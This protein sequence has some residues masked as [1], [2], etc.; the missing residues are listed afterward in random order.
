MLQIMLSR[1]GVTLCCAGSLTCASAIGAGKALLPGGLTKYDRDVVNQMIE[2]D[3]NLF[4]LQDD[5][6]LDDALRQAATQIAA[7]HVAHASKLW[8]IWIAQ[9]RVQAQNPELQG[10]GLVLALFV[11]AINELT[12][13][14]IESLGPAQDAIWLKAVLAPRACSLLPESPFAT[15]I[16]MIQ[17][18]APADRPALLAVEREL[19]SH[20]GTKRLN[21]PK[22][23][24][25]ADSHAAD[26]AIAKLRSG[27]AISAEPMTPNLAQQV[28]SQVRAPGPINRWDQ[29][30][31]SQWWLASQV[32]GGKVDPAAALS[33]FRYATMK[34]VQDF[35]PAGLVQKAAAASPR[36]AQAA[37]PPV[38]AYF[39]AEGTT[40]VQVDVDVNGQFVGA[41]VLARKVVVPGVRD[42]PPVAFE[43]LFD[44]AALQDAQRA[45][46]P[47]RQG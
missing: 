38:A 10:H 30:A 18:A 47:R 25:A 5:L 27:L 19:L 40:G 28:F 44:E 29:C 7:E 32:H 21:L 45:K 37:Y 20:W 41:Q 3:K 12:I 35:A 34:P 24:S 15:R 14:S 4:A 43:T 42:N 2:G 26:Q 36:A 16:A 23:P 39:G 6:V 17:A 9:E 22:R 8:P 31:K 11:R 13:L 33:N 1:L 46:L